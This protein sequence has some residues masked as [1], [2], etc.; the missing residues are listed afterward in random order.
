MKKFIPV[1]L[2]IIKFNE[3]DVITASPNGNGIDLPLDYFDLF[4]N[5]E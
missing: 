2:E 1:E 3:K 5:N 4:G